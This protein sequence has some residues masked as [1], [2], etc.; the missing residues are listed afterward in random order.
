MR[1]VWGELGELSAGE[2]AGEGYLGCPSLI[3]VCQ[4]PEGNEEPG[5]LEGQGCH[6]VTCCTSVSRIDSW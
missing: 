6:K 5:G 1:G 2:A 3:D 4:S